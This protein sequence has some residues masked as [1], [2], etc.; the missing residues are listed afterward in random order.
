MLWT[1]RDDVTELSS[2]TQCAFRLPRILDH[3]QCK[4]AEATAAVREALFRG[5]LSVSSLYFPLPFFLVPNVQIEGLR[6]FAQSP[7]MQGWAYQLFLVCVFT[8]KS[9]QL[10]AVIKINA[11]HKN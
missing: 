4:R 3:N 11:F 1:D 8:R 6:A 2:S 9:I 10:F 7:R 5:H